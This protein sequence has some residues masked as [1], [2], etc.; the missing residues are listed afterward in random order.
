MKKAPGS[1]SFLILLGK[2]CRGRTAPCLTSLVSGK[3]ASRGVTLIEVLVGLV[4]IVVASVSA[5][6]FFSYGLG[7]LGREGNERAA[8]ER[9]RERIEE[10]IAT[11]AAGLIPAD[12][13]ARWLTCTGQPCSWTLAA[14]QTAET[15]NVNDSGALQILTSARWVDDPSLGTANLDLVE[16][17][18]R[19]WFTGNTAEDN[20]MHRVRMRTLRTP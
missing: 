20:D 11:D 13:T 12:G 7:S 10:L 6:A 17:D 16:F 15:V 18:V 1:G 19:V 2:V 5:L 8:L 14:A 9:A 4:I 3:N